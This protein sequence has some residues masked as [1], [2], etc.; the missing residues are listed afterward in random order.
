LYSVI[1]VFA[2]GRLNLVCCDR[3]TTRRTVAASDCCH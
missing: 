3:S 2:S 1:V